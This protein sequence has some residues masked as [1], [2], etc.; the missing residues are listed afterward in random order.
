[1]RSLYLYLFLSIALSLAPATSIADERYPLEPPDTSI[2]RATMESFQNV[3]PD[4]KQVLVKSRKWGAF[5]K[6][7]RQEIK[8]LRS[9]ALH[10]IDLSKVP[11]RLVDHV[12]LEAVVLLAEILDRIELPPLGVIP[13]ADSLEAGKV[14]RWTI[15]HTEITIVRIE[16]GS[17]QG[18]YL[19]SPETVDRLKAYYTK[20]KALPYRPD[21]IIGKIGPAGLVG[22]PSI[23]P[24]HQHADY[25]LI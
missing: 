17:Q 22:F 21:A 3:M 19:F 5:S 8:R 2:P 12:G 14:S 24:K 15:P 11:E 6:E 7:A 25:A 18:D 23:Q 16:K 4:T 10:C 13:V 20:V 1:V 9:R